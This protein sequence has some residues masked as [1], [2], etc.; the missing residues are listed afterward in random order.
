MILNIFGAILMKEAKLQEGI[1]I[2]VIS[3][4]TGLFEDEALKI[5]K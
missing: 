1:K 4:V 2:S 3:K 5:N